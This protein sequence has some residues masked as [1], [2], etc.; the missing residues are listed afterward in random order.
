M[1]MSVVEKR[2]Q[3]CKRQGPKSGC[4]Y[5]EVILHCLYLADFTF[6][7]SCIYQ[8]PQCLYVGV[9][10]ASALVEHTVNNDHDFLRL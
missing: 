2:G 1:M 9:A 3:I 4:P 10:H 8:H 6:T 7:L 5:V